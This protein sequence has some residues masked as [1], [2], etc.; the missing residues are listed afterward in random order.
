MIKAER[1]KY[2]L[3]EL[4]LYEKVKSS[5]LCDILR[6]SE[7]TI[8]RDLIELENSGHLKKVHG[9]AITINFIPSF[10]KREV[11]EIQLKN[12]IARKALG[13][14]EENQVLIIDG[15]TS[16]LQLVNMLP[17]NTK[18]T[19]FTNSIPVA[20]KLC[21]NGDIDGVLLGGSILSKGHST[22]GYHSIQALH[23]IHADLCIMGITSIDSQYGLTEAH[24]EET[25]IK[26]EM[27]KSSNKVASLV[28]SQ[29]LMT[30]QPYSVC[31]I[32]SLDYLITELDPDHQSLRPFKEKG[33]KII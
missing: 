12:E 27:I 6:V 30:R 20:S 21:E 3:D 32:D 18:L 19:I 9:G 26:K 2:I 31:N 15:G 23:E 22:I 11:L 14:I 29:K 5:R 25:M 24:R 28:I 16:N 4:N 33:V 7:D 8:R 1:Q 10:K 17:K 13:L